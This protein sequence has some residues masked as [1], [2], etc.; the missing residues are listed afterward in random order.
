M[1]EASLEC[2][3][4]FAAI[5]SAVIAPSTISLLVTEETPVGVEFTS[6]VVP[7]HVQVREPDVYV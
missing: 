4:A 1:F 3:I 5:L 6:H 7:F 2:V